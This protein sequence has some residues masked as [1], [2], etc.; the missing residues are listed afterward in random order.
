MRNHVNRESAKSAK[1]ITKRGE[2]MI[3]FFLR[4][5]RAFAVQTVSQKGEI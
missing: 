4:V 3:L 1:K 5:L 2:A